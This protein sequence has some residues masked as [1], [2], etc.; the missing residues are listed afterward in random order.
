MTTISKLGS[1][2]TEPQRV[3]FDNGERTDL[4]FS[5]LCH[6]MSNLTYSQ[7]PIVFKG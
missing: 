3:L 7:T 6:I 5:P 2:A 4:M 1:H